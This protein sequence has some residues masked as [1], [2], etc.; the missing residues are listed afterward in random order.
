MAGWQDWIFGNLPPQPVQHPASHGSAFGMNYQPLPTSRNIED[1]RT[2]APAFD[3]EEMAPFIDPFGPDP[4]SNSMNRAG[5]LVDAGAAA[6]PANPNTGAYSASF[7]RYFAPPPQQGWRQMPAR[8]GPPPA[9]TLPYI[10][11]HQPI[12]PSPVGWSPH[13]DSPSIG[14][15]FTPQQMYAAQQN[16]QQAGITPDQMQGALQY[17]QG[18]AQ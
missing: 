14:T 2:G 13:N 1:R 6:N 11:P 3:P 4:V 10:D 9:L 16:R 15:P 12:A 5:N 17:W 18:G 7:N 8:P